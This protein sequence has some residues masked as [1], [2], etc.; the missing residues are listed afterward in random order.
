[1]DSKD[2]ILKDY[3][4]IYSGDSFEHWQV[5]YRRK[6]VLECI[7]KHRPKTLLEIGCGMDPLFNYLDKDI[8]ITVVEPCIEFYDNA[9][10]MVGDK[11]KVIKGY[12]EEVI[13]DGII[14]Q[15]Y[16]YIVCSSLLHEVDHPKI[17]LEAIKKIATDNTIIHINVPNAFSIHRV[18]AEK[19][20]IISS[21]YT[22]SA[23]QKSLQQA[24]IVYDIS[25]LKSLVEEE[26]FTVIESG[27]YFVKPF[28]HLQMQKM[29]NDDIINESVLDGLYKLTEI[30]PEYGSEIFVECQLKI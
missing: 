18:L 24:D 6:K 4:R 9:K 7:K 11:N 21:V 1:M 25:S 3:Y 27:S 5:K 14:K 28:T 30:L 17:I 26:G 29:I 23:S 15:E 16:E 20:G 10:K 8:Y 2:R 19:M 13:A 12:I 22:Q